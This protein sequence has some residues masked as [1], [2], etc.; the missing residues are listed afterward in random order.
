MATA[1]SQPPSLHSSS[2]VEELTPCVEPWDLSR[3][4]ACL[5]H[6][7][8]LESVSHPSSLGR[9]S[10]LTADPVEWICSRGQAVLLNGKLL[11]ETDPFVA[12]AE[13]LGRFRSEALPGLPPFQG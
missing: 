3:K 10:F 2:C 5:P 9:Y 8:L 7:L 12:L 1:V 4:L 13:R 6:L 11:P